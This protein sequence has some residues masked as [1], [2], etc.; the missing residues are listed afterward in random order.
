MEKGR[1]KIE[2]TLSEKEYIM[3]EKSLKIDLKDSKIIVDMFYTV[4]KDITEYIEIE[5]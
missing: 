3:D 1:S 5:G 2:E 4:Y